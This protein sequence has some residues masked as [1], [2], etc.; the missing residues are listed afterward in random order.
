MTITAVPPS[1]LLAQLLIQ[2]GFGVAH[3]VDEDWQVWTAN[4]PDGPDDKDEAISVK[5]TTGA[6]DGRLM[7]TM[8]RI[9]H[10]GIQIRVRSTDYLIGYSKARDIAK[11][12]DTIQHEEIVSTVDNKS[13]RIPSVTR[14]QVIS[15]GKELEGRSRELFSIN[16]VLTVKEN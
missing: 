13:Y 8:E 14:G 12:L 6:Q 10:P 9:E 16:A 15:M 1:Y 11:Y 3:D 7:K 5:D 4:L 2:Q